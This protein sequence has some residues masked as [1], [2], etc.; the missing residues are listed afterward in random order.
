MRTKKDEGV[1]GFLKGQEGEIKGAPSACPYVVVSLREIAPS[2]F[3]CR[4]RC[5]VA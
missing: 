2:L 5:A 3:E 4:R 1:G